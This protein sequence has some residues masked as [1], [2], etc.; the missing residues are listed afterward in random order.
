MNSSEC[1]WSASSLAKIEFGCDYILK[2][3]EHNGWLHLIAFSSFSLLSGNAN[4][5]AGTRCRNMVRGSA[6]LTHSDERIRQ[7]HLELYFVLVLLLRIKNPYW[8]HEASFNLIQAMS[9][10]VLWHWSWHVNMELYKIITFWSWVHL[11]DP[12]WE[13][14]A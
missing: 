4:I 11:R 9:K 13:F 2:K 6:I 7:C 12:F 3:K 10:A 8:K 5:G 14:E 1:N